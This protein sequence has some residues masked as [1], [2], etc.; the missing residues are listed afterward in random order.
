MP[1]SIGYMP[2]LAM[3]QYLVVYDRG[4]QENGTWRGYYDSFDELADATKRA[5][6]SHIDGYDCTIFDVMTGV[7]IAR[8]A[9]ARAFVQGDATLQASLSHK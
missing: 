3:A 7:V 1:S 2:G 5:Q 9:V 4:F 6:Q 8:Y